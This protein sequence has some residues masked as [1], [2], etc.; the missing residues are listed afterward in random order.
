M[1]RPLTA[2]SI[3][4]A[5]VIFGLLSAPAARASDADAAVDPNAE[6]IEIT[7]TRIPEEVDKVPY[8]MTIVSGADLRAR[9]ARD[10]RG[11]L[12]LA[13]GI[14]IAPGGDGG[15]AGSVPEIWG[16]RE[17]D[18]FLLVVDGVPWGGV[19][20][21]ALPTLDLTDV[22]RIEV[23]RGPAPVMYGATSF[24]GVIHVI[25]TPPGSTGPA[26]SAGARSYGGAALY[27]QAP[28][29]KWGGL[30][31]SV[32]ADIDRQGYR[33]DRT[34][35]DRGHLAWRGALSAGKGT[36]GLRADGTWLRQDPASPHPRVG[37]D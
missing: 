6:R 17:F 32:S 2:G 13:A 30:S 3:A 20:A 19:F 9:G 26:A 28:L 37:E 25:H 36:L 18:A 16:L 31:S 21:P 27:G 22:D 4:P 11:A 10:L 29:P 14:D 8:A 1:R 7:A 12:T 24:S 33:D 34:Q 5:V 23:V 15:P 35:A